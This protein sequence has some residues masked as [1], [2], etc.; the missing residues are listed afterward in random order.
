MEDKRGSR[1][2]PV[3]IRNYT[4]RLPGESPRVEIEP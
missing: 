4:R 1:N 2:G 3:V